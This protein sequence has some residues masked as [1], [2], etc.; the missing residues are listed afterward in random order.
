MSRVGKQIQT[1]RERAGF[2]S[3]DLAKKLGVAENFIS[4]VENGRKIINEDLIKRI[5]KILGASLSDEA[6]E[7][8]TEPLENIKEVDSTKT[9]NKQWEEAFSHIIKK[10]PV[11]DESFK[12]IFE[13]KYIPVMDKKIDGYNAEKITYVKVPDDSMRGFRIQRDDKVMIFLNPEIVNNGILLIEADGKRCLRQIKR[14]DSNKVLVISQ[15]NELK[16]E[17][18]DVKSFV[19]IGRCLKLEVEF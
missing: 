19:V 9:V 15:S 14:L 10:I 3:K 13:Y 17:T 18:R 6:L 7:E 5:E 11:C 4:D 2:S 8:I 12:E 16:T 1:A